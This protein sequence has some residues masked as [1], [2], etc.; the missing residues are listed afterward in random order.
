MADV[1]AGRLLDM[2]MQANRLKTTPRTG[3]FQRGVPSPESVADHSHGVA[4][5]SLALLGSVPEKLDRA[6]VL[7]MAIAH[8]LAESVTGDLS[9]GASRLL[10][11]GAKM[12]AESAALDEL[13]AGIGFAG[14]WM[15]LWAEF[16][17]QAT[18]EARLVRDADRLDLLAT[19]LS[20][21]L[22]TGTSCLEEF[23]RFA[24][25]SGFTYEVSREL[26]RGLQERRP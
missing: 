25:E 11:P 17:A 7:A 8:D 26:V 9:L 10:P 3:W 1:V 14:E 24:P 6:K 12:A 23:W 16:E 21:E 22:S 4:L 20:Y 19:A 5:I 15:D 2:L 13:L 18:P